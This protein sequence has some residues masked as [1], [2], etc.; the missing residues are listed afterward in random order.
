MRIR[1]SD[2]FMLYRLRIR[3]IP[4]PASMPAHAIQSTCGN[5]PTLVALHS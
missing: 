4:S 2:Y 5:R 1:V 3:H